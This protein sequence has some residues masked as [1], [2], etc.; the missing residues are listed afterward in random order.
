MTLAD[1]P[2]PRLTFWAVCL[3]LALAG[4]GCTREY[5]FTFRDAESDRPL[6]GR[7]VELLSLPR[8]YS[9]LDLRHYVCESGEPVVETGR[10]DVNGRVV[11]ALPEDL[12]IR[13]V[14]LDGRWFAQ[15]PSSS[16]QPMRTRE[17]FEA[18]TAPLPPCAG[19]PKVRMKAE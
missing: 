4:V 14:Q 2:I 1:M 11:F 8:I 12:G 3:C 17:E 13:H 19:R 7:P 9:F 16:F 10:T 5:V 6:V 15:Q 18:R